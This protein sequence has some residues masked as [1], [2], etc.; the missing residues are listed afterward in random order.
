MSARAVMFGRGAYQEYRR[1]KTDW[2]PRRRAYAL[3]AIA[4]AALIGVLLTTRNKGDALAIFASLPIGVRVLELGKPLAFQV[5]RDG[6]HM[7][8]VVISHAVAVPH[9]KVVAFLVDEDTASLR[10]S[11]NNKRIPEGLYCSF[12]DGSTS[13]VEL[14]V[15]AMLNI[16]TCS[17]W[18]CA[19]RGNPEYVE[20][21]SADLRQKL[22]DVSKIDVQQYWTA[23]TTGSS[24][25]MNAS[26]LNPVGTTRF[27]L[28]GNIIQNSFVLSL[29]ILEHPDY[30]RYLPSYAKHYMAMGVKDFVIYVN[31]ELR[32]STVEALRDIPAYI[33]VI[34]MNPDTLQISR[35]RAKRREVTVWSST[36]IVWRLRHRAKWS[37]TLEAPNEL[38]VGVSNMPKYFDKI[39]SAVSSVMMY[40]FPSKT[41]NQVPCVFPGAMFGF[42]QI[43]GPIRSAVRPELSD[44]MLENAPSTNRGG[45]MDTQTVKIVMCDSEAKDKSDTKTWLK[46]PDQS[47]LTLADVGKL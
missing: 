31:A 3:V 17:V 28:H 34:V 37:M 29:P 14:H 22:S 30:V 8:V 33:T 21:R 39:D 47:S 16:Q 26:L 43:R 46:H 9:E 25:N 6:G 35:K 27:E 13:P 11:A 36:D 4:A 20:I 10:E 24:T 1:V 23:S 12:P 19:L 40:R 5:P 32:D 44:L 42:P 7:A 38:A 45:S 41:P 18:T 2:R 15:G